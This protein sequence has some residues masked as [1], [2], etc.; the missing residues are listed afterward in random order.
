MW[1][2]SE[3]R[4]RRD[5]AQLAGREA[6]KTGQPFVTPDYK[7]GDE[8]ANWR[9]GWKKEAAKAGYKWPVEH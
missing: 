5:A 8:A 4:S 7:R 2:L 1:A 6:F 9:L 3:D